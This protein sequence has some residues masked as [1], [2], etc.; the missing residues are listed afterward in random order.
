[1]ER[2]RRR[3]LV[4]RPQP[5]SASLCLSLSLA[6]ARPSLTAHF[7]VAWLCA[8]RTTG[9]TEG[10]D[11]PQ[12]RRDPRKVCQARRKSRTPISRCE[13]FFFD[14]RRVAVNS[15]FNRIQE[16]E[17]VA[18][19]DPQRNW[20]WRVAYDNITFNEVMLIGVVQVSAGSWMPILQLMNRVVI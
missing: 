7:A 16:C 10:S 17:Q 3:H 2:A 5:R 14:S 9:P 1:M 13:F 12:E 18:V 4:T 8:L 20:K 6:Y 19:Q 15:K 11:S